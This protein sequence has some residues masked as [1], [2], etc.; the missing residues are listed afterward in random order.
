MLTLDLGVDV[1]EVVD[2]F[3]LTRVL[4][5]HRR[6]LFLEVADDERMN[7]E[8]R[9]PKHKH[10][11]TNTSQ[12]EEEIFIKSSIMIPYRGRGSVE[13]VLS[14]NSKVVGSTHTHATA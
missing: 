4:A 5:E 13:T 8:T 9:D 14:C 10:F 7:L 11:P 12:S 2:E 3:F 6:H 1:A